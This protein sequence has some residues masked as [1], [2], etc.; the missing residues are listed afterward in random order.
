MTPKGDKNKWGLQLCPKCN[1]MTNHDDDG[2]L[3]CRSK[4]KRV[5]SEYK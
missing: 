5:N 2:C 3:K 1:Q 4:S